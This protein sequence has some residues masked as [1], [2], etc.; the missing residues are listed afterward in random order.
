MML[1]TTNGVS[2]AI[3]PDMSLCSDLQLTLPYITSLMV[4]LC[5]DVHTAEVHGLFSLISKIFLRVWMQLETMQTTKRCVPSLSLEGV[6]LTRSCSFIRKA[7]MRSACTGFLAMKF[8]CM[9]GTPATN[10]PMR[11]LIIG[12]AR[13]GPRLASSSIIWSASTTTAQSR[14]A[15]CK[16]ATRALSSSAT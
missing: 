9:V 5:K 14:R 7:Y 11:T 10:A 3:S 15:Y 2:L 12:T 8:T 6:V 16:S 1:V 13:N 4:V